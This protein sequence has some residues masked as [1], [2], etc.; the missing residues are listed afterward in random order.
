MVDQPL[1]A[2]YPL[3]LY[4]GDTRV[5]D[6]TLER[7]TGTAEVPVW[8]PVD[9]TGH[10]FDAE[11]RTAKD[12]TAVLAEIAVASTAPTTG[13]L[14][15]T[16]TATEAAKLVGTS[17]FWDLEVTRTSDGFVRTYLAGKV[18]VRGDVSRTP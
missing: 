15:L 14:R 17:A 13:V 2:D 9:L 1:P 7:N 6:I 10:T 4:R 18:K 11:I 16:L 5:F 8:A 12:D 3:V